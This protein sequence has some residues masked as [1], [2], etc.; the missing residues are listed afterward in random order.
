[1]KRLAVFDYFPTNRIRAG[2]FCQPYFVANAFGAERLLAAVG[3]HDVDQLAL[4]ARAAA[5]VAG[6]GG[7]SHHGN[8]LNDGI[9]EAG[10]LRWG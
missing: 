3:L 10:Y 8:W 1:M 6:G 2:S 7:S 5:V 4:D 9:D